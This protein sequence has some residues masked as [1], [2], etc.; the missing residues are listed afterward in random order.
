MSS[1]AQSNASATSLS[2]DVPSVAADAVLVK[3]NFDAAGAQVM[4]ILTPS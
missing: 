2:E 4:I 3:S 1:S